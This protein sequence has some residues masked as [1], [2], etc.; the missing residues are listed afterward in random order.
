MVAVHKDKNNGDALGTGR[1][2]S[3]VA[4][5]AFGSAAARSRSTRGRW[6]STLSWNSIGKRCLSRF[7]RSIGATASTMVIRVSGGG[8]TGQADACKM[9]L[10]EHW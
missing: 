6:T 5:G 10:A 4:R 7:K 9:G 8:V 3:A 1:R 2:K